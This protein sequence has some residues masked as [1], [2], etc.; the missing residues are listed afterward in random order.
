MLFTLEMYTVLMDSE[1]TQ[2]MEEERT[3]TITASG[4]DRSPP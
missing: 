4:C 1:D 3:V 2:G